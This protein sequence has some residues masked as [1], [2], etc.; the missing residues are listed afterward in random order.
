MPPL[1]VM[2][3]GWENEHLAAFLLSRI[4]FVA[5]PLKVGDDIGSDFFCTLFKHSMQNGQE[6]LYPLNSFAVQVKSNPGIV[7]AI[8]VIGYLE[9]LELP[10]F[11]GV[12]DRSKLSLSLYSGEYLPMMFSEHGK[13]RG[14]RLYPEDGP[15]KAHSEPYSYTDEKQCHLKLPLVSTIAARDTPDTVS[16]NAEHLAQ[17]CS[18]MHANISTWKLDEYVF[19]LPADQV[20][21]MAGSGSA[22]TFRRNFYWRLEEVFHN[23]K[24]I[25]ENQ[26][27]E[28]SLAEFKVYERTYLDLL[29][30]RN[31]L[32][33]MTAVLKK[34]RELIL[35]KHQ[36]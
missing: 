7:D 32:P 18:R 5:N 21:I 22:K 9:Q 10:Y 33:N 3:K 24:W 6:M 19:R 15:D 12:I 4:A 20:Q 27:N 16:Q 28:F 34:L 35:K 26:P 25:L 31:D 14:L 8:K 30:I 11:L 13:P 23:M 2:R 17:L 36:A 29:R 1:A